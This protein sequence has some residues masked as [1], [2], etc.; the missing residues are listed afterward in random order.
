MDTDHTGSYSEQVVSDNRPRAVVGNVDVC[1][2]DVVDA[3]AK[4]IVLDEPVR[5]VNRTDADPDAVLCITLKGDVIMG[6]VV[7][8]IEVATLETATT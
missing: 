2:R 7:G 8:E 6:G 3:L 4:H 5:A 1:S